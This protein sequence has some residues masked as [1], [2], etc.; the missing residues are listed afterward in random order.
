MI[1]APRHQLLFKNTFSTS[2]NERTEVIQ[3]VGTIIKSNRL[4]PVISDYELTLIV[5]EAVTNA[6]EHGNSWN[7]NKKVFV[8]VRTDGI[9]LH[10]SIEDEGMGFDY[11]HYKSECEQNKLSKRGRGVMILRHLC[12]PF[13]GKSGREVILEI[14]LKSIP[15]KALPVRDPATF[16]LQ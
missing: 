8:S 2:Q 15:R 7:P 13:W 12:K 6:M 11:A 10:V 5:D 4:V 1:P 16:A 9:S 3:T 14:P